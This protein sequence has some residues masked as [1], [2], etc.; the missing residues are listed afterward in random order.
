VV[1]SDAAPVETRGLTR[2]FGSKLACDGLTLRVPRG[3]IFG[4]LGCNGAGKS[5]IIKMLMGLIR[6]SSGEARVLGAPPGDLSA[7]A[8][9][10]FLPENFRYS[11]WATGAEVLAFHAAL[12]RVPG[13]RRRGRIAFVLDMVGLRDDGRRLVGTY[14]KGMQQRLGIACALLADPPLLFLD[15]P[16]SALDPLGRREVRELLVRLRAEGKTLFL[17]EVEM[18][19]DRVAV[20]RAGR[21][22]ASGTLDELL[23]AQLEAEVQVGADDPAAVAAVAARGR[24]VGREQLPGGLVRLRLQIAGRGEVPAL[25]EAVVRAGGRLHGLQAR[26]RSLEDVFVDLVAA[27]SEP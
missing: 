7:R 3:G 8:H 21:L 12:A 5:T 24:V 15:E 18:V 27:Q 25:A 20:I 23:N 17:S 1:G 14:S 16:T 9:L 22:V 4:L 19:A 26:S 6:P 2:R 10:G 11:E 13:V